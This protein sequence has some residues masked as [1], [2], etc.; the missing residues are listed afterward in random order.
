MRLYLLQVNF[1]CENVYKWALATNDKL[2]RRS[3]PKTRYKNKASSQDI[4]GTN[5]YLRYED[6]D[7]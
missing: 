1:S 3:T 4:L 6:I 5:V 2:L 7:K